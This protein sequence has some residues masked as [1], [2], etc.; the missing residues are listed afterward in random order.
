MLIHCWG[1]WTKRSFH[2]RRPAPCLWGYPALATVDLS[3]GMPNMCQD[4]PR[5]EPFQP[6]RACLCFF[7]FLLF[8]IMS[9]H[10]LGA[11]FCCRGMLYPLF[12][13]VALV[14][15]RLQARNLLGDQ[16]HFCVRLSN[17]IL[18]NMVPWMILDVFHLFLACLDHVMVEKSSLKCFFCI[19]CNMHA[20]AKRVAHGRFVMLC[21]AFGLWYIRLNLRQL[22]N[23]SQYIYGLVMLGDGWPYLLR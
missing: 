9:S 8:P 15:L 21:D 4:H 17:I 20:Y 14:A 12:G 18:A 19:S 2:W 10:F 23:T 1:Q 7:M 11:F 3:L 16:R 6:F 22:P 13:V 5:S